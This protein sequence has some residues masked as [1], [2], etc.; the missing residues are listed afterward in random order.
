[1]S[2]FRLRTGVISYR[3]GNV[4]CEIFVALATASPRPGGDGHV[5]GAHL[6]FCDH[7][8]FDSAEYERQLKE[9]F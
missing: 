7:A 8:R 2:I 9:A 5:V 6:A 3:F 1:M 4:E